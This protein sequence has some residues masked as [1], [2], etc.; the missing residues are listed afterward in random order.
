LPETASTKPPS[1]WAAYPAFVLGVFV[2]MITLVALRVEYYKIMDYKPEMMPQIAYYLIPI[3]VLI[4]LV[5]ASPSEALLRRYWYAPRSRLQAVLI[6]IGYATLLVWWAFPDHWAV[7]L[8][9]NP[10]TIRWLVSMRD[11]K[12]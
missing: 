10:F 1:F 2:G 7:I 5:I 12:T 11:G 8:V 9:V 6:G 4:V 3:L